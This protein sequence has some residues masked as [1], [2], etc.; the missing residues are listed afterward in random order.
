M[1]IKLND[2]IEIVKQLLGKGYS[3]VQ[4]CGEVGLDWEEFWNIIEYINDIE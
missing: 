1:I 3:D 2:N 4:I